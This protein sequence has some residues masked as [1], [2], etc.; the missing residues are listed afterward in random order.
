MAEREGFEH[1]ANVPPL[2]SLSNPYAATP[3]VTPSFSQLPVISYDGE[4][5]RTGLDFNSNPIYAVQ[6]TM[7]DQDSDESDSASPESAYPERSY[8]SAQEQ[9]YRHGQGRYG[10]GISCLLDSS[11]CSNTGLRAIKHTRYPGS[12]DAI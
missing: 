7:S 1:C 10:L 5:F 11:L 8:Q 6:T 4:R 2:L 3:T 9:K 12:I